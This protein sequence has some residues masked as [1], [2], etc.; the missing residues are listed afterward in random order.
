MREVAS[1]GVDGPIYTAGLSQRHAAIGILDNDALDPRVIRFVFARIEQ[2]RRI[3]MHL[4]STRR[5]NDDPKTILVPVRARKI[6][7]KL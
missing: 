4:Q 3:V 1:D 6:S 5:V 2:V 7:Y